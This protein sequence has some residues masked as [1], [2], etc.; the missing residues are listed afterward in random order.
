MIDVLGC[1]DPRKNVTQTVNCR[2]SPVR[3][4]L[5]MTWTE[6][7]LDGRTDLYV[8]PRGGITAAIHRSDI[9]EHNLLGNMQARL[10]MDSL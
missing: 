8:F 3:W 5:I 4:G 7:P 10:V 9:V 1:G 6:I 2:S